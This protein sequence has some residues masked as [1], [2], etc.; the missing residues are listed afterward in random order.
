MNSASHYLPV[1]KCEFFNAGGSVKDRIGLRMI[2]DA[3]ARGDIKPGDVLIE[4]TSG[5]T[6]IGIALA[7][8]VKGYRCI[9]VVQENMSREKVGVF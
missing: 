1:V 6:G 3:E 4:S 2:E 5:N 7:S 9:I 8:A